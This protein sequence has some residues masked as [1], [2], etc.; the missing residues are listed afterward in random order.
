M[1]IIN[2][3]S[4]RAIAKSDLHTKPTHN[5]IGEFRKREAVVSNFKI[6][7]AKVSGRVIDVFSRTVKAGTKLFTYRGDVYPIWF[8]VGKISGDRHSVDLSGLQASIEINTS[9]EKRLITHHTV[10]SDQTDKLVLSARAHAFRAFNR[11]ATSSLNFYTSTGTPTYDLLLEWQDADLLWEEPDVGTSTNLSKVISRS[12]G[13]SINISARAGNAGYQST[14]L[15]ENADVNWGQVSSAIYQS[16]TGASLGLGVTT[17]NHNL[18]KVIERNVDSSITLGARAG[19]AGYTTNL[20]WENADVDWQSLSGGIFTSSTDS[21]ISINTEINYEI[22]R[23][24][25]RD[26]DSSISLSTDISYN[27]AKVIDRDVSSSITFGATAGTAGYNSSLLWENADV[28]WQSV[29]GGIFTS[30]ALAE[31]SLATNASGSTIVMWSNASDLFNN[32][33]KNWEDI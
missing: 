7:D 30:T 6:I 12:A 19:T 27:L 16:S 10:R 13:T 26:I 25:K 11:S 17:I 23:L 4:R 29:S 28:N 9:A 8:T 33:T 18:A 31:F 21:S 3:S 2:E 20:L 14:L 32:L 5:Q 1:R 22:S 24:Y 15:W